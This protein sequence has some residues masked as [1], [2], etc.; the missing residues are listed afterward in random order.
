VPRTW[1]ITK[2][3]TFYN[4]FTAVTNPVFAYAGHFMFFILISEMKK[5]EDAMK[6]AYTLQSFATLFYICFAV[7]C[8]LYLGDSVA[9]P[10]FSSLPILWQKIAFGVAIPNFLI[11]GALYAHTASKLIFVRLFR[12]SRHLHSNT[13]VGWS[14]WTFLI[15]IMNGAAFVLAVGVPIFNYI[16]GLA[17]SLVRFEHPPLGV[18][19]RLTATSLVCLMV[20][21]RHR[22][23][24]LAA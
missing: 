1:E 3:T 7:V 11:A 16:V 2:P 13:V 20:Y 22:R 9:S 18:L 23:L 12:N 17:A 15:I 21:L 19:L 5:P 8:Y 14:S 4:A 10:A 24:L 6:A